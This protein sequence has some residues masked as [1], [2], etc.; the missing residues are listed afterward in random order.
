MQ[1]AKIIIDMLFIFKSILN[2]HFDELITNEYLSRASKILTTYL[3]MEL[4]A[5]IKA[6]IDH[7]SIANHIAV[8]IDM[9]LQVYYYYYYYGYN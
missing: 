7:A 4:K 6:K 3:D 5:S 2:N 9:H 1:L 8:N